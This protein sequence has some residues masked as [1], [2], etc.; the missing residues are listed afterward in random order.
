M[1]GRGFQ[2]IVAA[3]DPLGE[4]SSDQRALIGALDMSVASLDPAAPGG[5]HDVDGR[6]TAWL[7]EH[8]AHAV[9]VRPDFYVFGSC[10]SPGE[11]PDLLDDLQTQL[12][13]TY[14]TATAGALP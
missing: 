6:L 7:T 4:L 14:T 3:G 11:L 2:L 9:L 1:I 10:P 13:L 8:K 5:V 12:Q